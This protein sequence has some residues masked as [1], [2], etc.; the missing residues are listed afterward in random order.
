MGG[1]PSRWIHGRRGVNKIVADDLIVDTGVNGQL[2]IKQ[3]PPHQGMEK[4]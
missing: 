3:E 1:D 2:P 4:W